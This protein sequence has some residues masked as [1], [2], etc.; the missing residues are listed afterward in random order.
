MTG[1]MTGSLDRYEWLNRG[2]DP[3]ETGPRRL[4]VSW[5]REGVLGSIEEL[6]K[7]S[8]ELNSWDLFCLSEDWTD[9]DSE[10][11]TELRGL[12]ERE[13]QCLQG[14][15]RGLAE[16]DGPL[17]VMTSGD[18]PFFLREVGLVDLTR[19]EM[20]LF[21]LRHRVKQCR[22]PGVELLRKFGHV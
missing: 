12:L 9:R 22:P 1:V 17:W 10:D 5:L 18:I 8:A 7:I 11:L 21:S 3:S 4:S 16:M 19:L 13:L 14:F 6:G 15:L 2:C 20:R